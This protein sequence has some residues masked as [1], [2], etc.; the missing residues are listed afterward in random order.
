[1]PYIQLLLIPQPSAKKFAGFSSG[2]PLKLSGLS[3]ITIGSLITQFN[4]YR[5][6]DSQIRQVYSQT[7]IIVSMETVLTRDVSVIVKDTSF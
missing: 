3:G 6:P 4:A 1:M 2:T 5:S 7:G